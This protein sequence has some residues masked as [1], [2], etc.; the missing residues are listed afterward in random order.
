LLYYYEQ[1]KIDLFYNILY[2][3]KGIVFI[4]M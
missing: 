2:E 3:L 4:N 1:T